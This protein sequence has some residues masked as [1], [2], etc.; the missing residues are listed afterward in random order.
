MTVL[1]RCATAHRVG[2]L[3][4]IC[5]AAR[6]CAPYATGTLQR[7]SDS[8]M[9]ERVG[10]QTFVYTITPLLSGPSVASAEPLLVAPEGA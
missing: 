3:L 9:V 5:L 1:A 6:A 2:A 7:Q 10:F 8:V 4:A